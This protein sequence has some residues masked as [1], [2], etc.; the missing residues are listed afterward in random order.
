MGDLCSP[1]PKSMKVWLSCQGG[2]LILTQLM[3][4]TQ[5]LRQTSPL[6]MTSITGSI[7]SP[8]V[9]V[10]SLPHPS[11]WPE[12]Y[13][14]HQNLLVRRGGMIFTFYK[15]RGLSVGSSLVEEDKLELAKSLEAA[16]KEKGVEFILP[17]DVIIADKFDAEAN[18]QTVS[19][20]AIPDGWMVRCRPPPLLLIPC[21]ADAQL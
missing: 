4:F 16:A 11:E 6:G 12:L 20:D 10:F 17:T 14:K 18:T 3:T 5:E 9:K 2:C 13:G 1:V 15:A 21:S 7:C 19:A 8:S